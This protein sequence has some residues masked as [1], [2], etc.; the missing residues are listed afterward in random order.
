MSMFFF[1]LIS[2]VPGNL[3][4]NPLL[5]CTLPSWDILKYTMVEAAHHSISLH[6][7]MTAKQATV[8]HICQIRFRKAC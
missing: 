4:F 1:S 6:H 3:S 8:K 5:L 7:A 2:K